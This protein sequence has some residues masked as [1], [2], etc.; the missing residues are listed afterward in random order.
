[1]TEMKNEHIKIIVK[2]PKCG[3]RILDKTHRVTCIVELKCPHCG[4]I[5]PIDLSL[6]KSNRN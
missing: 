6:R 3:K 1:M 4:N 5:V 2:C